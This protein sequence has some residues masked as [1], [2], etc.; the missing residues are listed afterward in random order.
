MTFTI[1]DPRESGILTG[2]SSTGNTK[3]KFKTG[4]IVSFKSSIS[5]NAKYFRYGLK[6]LE[7]HNG[8]TGNISVCESNRSNVW[9]VNTSELELANKPSKISKSKK[10]LITGT[11]LFSSLQAG[12]INENIYLRNTYQYKNLINLYFNKLNKFII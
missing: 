10:L 2:T 6:N 1:T 3:K 7:V 11:I 4:D 9:S 12:M 5:Q 8:G